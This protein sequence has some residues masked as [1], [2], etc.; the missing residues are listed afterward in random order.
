MSNCKIRSEVDDRYV[1][2]F[3]K[4]KRLKIALEYYSNLENWKCEI[5]NDFNSPQN[6]IPAIEDRGKVARLALE[7]N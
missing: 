6:V 1:K 2:M 4:V 7:N 5:Y 3:D